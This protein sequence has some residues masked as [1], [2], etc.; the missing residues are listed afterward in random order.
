MTISLD[1]AG[2]LIHPAKPVGAVYSE[3]LARETGLAIEPERMQSAFLLRIVR[4][5][6]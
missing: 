2:T 3:V 1:A 6:S 4:T 5:P